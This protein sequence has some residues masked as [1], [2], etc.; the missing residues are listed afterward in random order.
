M[1]VSFFFFFTK[2]VGLATAI[3]FIGPIKAKPNIC[4]SERKV[5][6]GPILHVVEEPM[7]KE[8]ELNLR[9][10]SQQLL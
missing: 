2:R 5:L 1:F 3:F 10:F 7:V 8:G 4:A 6:D 9:V